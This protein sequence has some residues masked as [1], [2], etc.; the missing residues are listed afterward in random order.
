MIVN[1]IASGQQECV[2]KIYMLNKLVNKNP[3]FIRRISDAPSQELKSR[4]KARIKN[5]EP[6]MKK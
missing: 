5:I 1:H 6:S 2:G 4:N 3:T